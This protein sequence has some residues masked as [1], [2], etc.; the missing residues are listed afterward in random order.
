MRKL[1]TL[2]LILMV[3]STAFCQTPSFMV[4][5]P[6]FA[7]PTIDADLSDWDAD[8]NTEWIPIDQD[9]YGNGAF[10]VQQAYYSVKWSPDTNLIYLA[11]KFNDYDNNF[12]AQCTGWD[13]QDGI[14]IY[15]DAGNSNPENDPNYHFY[16]DSAQQFMAGYDGLGGSWLVLADYRPAVADV[17]DYAVSY[18]NFSLIFEFALEPWT[19]RVYRL[20]R[21]LGPYQII[22]LDIVISSVRADDEFGRFGMKCNNTMTNKSGYASQF[23]DHQLK[24]EGGRPPS[25]GD[26]LDLGYFIAEDVNNDCHVDVVELNMFLE[27]WMSCMDPGVATCDH[28]WPQ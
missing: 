8:P 23:Q 9:Y 6:T 19:S 17:N 2:S 1:L 14:E 10:D 28:P 21:N 3:G 7:V 24:L 4:P 12:Q 18:N 5:I 16:F 27:Q 20:K 26:V 22:G 13:D 15:L 11:V 25:C